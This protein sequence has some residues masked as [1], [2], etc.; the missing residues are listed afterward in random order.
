M[1]K[2]QKTNR[3]EEKVPLTRGQ[4]GESNPQRWFC[5][6][7]GYTIISESIA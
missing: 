5:L 6:F 4:S 1:G 2:G 3:T 7:Q